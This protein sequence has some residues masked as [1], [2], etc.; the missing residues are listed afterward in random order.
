VARAEVVP[1]LV[2]ERQGALRVQIAILARALFRYRFIASTDLYF[3][4]S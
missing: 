3:R 1:D 4:S 2:G